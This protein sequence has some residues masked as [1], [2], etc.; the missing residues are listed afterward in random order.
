MIVLSHRIEF[1]I[2]DQNNSLSIPELYNP[3]YIYRV[4]D[5]FICND[6][7]QEKEDKVTIGEFEVTSI[8]QFLEWSLLGSIQ[9]WVCKIKE[10]GDGIGK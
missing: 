10:I 8:K 1:E 5:K 9:V 2:E 6:V 4:G 7:Y 3:V